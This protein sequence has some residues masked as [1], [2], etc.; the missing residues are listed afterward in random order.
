MTVTVSYDAASDRFVIT[1]DTPG[2]TSTVEITAI[3]TN[4]N[5][6]FGF[7]VGNGVDGTDL[8]GTINGLSATSN[9]RFLT[10][11]SG[12]SKGLVVEVLSGGTGYRGTVSVSRGLAFKV[13]EVLNSFL[14]SD[15]IIAS[16]EDGLNEGLEDIAEQRLDLD[17]RISTLEARLIQQFTTL[18]SLIAQFNNTSSF[19]TLQLANLPK[20]NSIG[21]NS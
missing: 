15:G 21:N 1:S 5:A 6:H 17:A 3:D 13:D 8:A 16:R 19:L 18:D 14:G 7:S 2:S 4:T 12:D 20:P 10:S 11:D 9:G